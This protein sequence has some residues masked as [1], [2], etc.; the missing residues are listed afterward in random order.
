MDLWE[1]YVS[2]PQN[3]NIF[4]KV[5][6]WILI[7]AMDTNVIQINIAY[8]HKYVL[9]MCVWEGE[10]GGNLIANWIN[11]TKLKWRKK[12]HL[13]S[14]WHSQRWVTPTFRIVK[15]NKWND[16]FYASMNNYLRYIWNE[17]M[18]LITNYKLAP[19]ICWWDR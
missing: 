7:W 2:C 15:R 8:I 16:S 4:E 5:T 11:M 3:W 10:R 19:F 18:T 17:S 13:I 14:V 1:N 6:I 12:T 9:C